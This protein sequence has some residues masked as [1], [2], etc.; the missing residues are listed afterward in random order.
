[1]T[2][3][4]RDGLSKQFAKDDSAIV[5]LRD[6]SLDIEASHSATG[7]GSAPARSWRPR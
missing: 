4:L 3:V 5:A 7:R 6:F 1:M 2:A